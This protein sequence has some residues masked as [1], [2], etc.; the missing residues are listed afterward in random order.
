MPRNA[1]TYPYVGPSDIGER[2]RPGQAATAVTSQESLDVWL[3]HRSRDE[4]SEPFTFVISIDGELR[5]APRRSEHVDCAAG[6][7]ILA[8]GEIGFDRQDGCWTVTEVSNLSTGYCPGPDSWPAVAAALDRVD[9]THPDDFTHKFIFRRCTA[10]G[11]SNI[12]RDNAYVC[13]VCGSDL[14]A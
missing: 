6:R 5:L 3:S 10:C 13:A 11:Q 1:R 9:L 7:E 14:P 12:V 8:A 4:L 2:A